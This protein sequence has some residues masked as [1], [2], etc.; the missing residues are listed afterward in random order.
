MFIESLGNLASPSNPDGKIPFCVAENKLT[1]DRLSPRFIKAASVAFSNHE[2]WEYNDMTGLSQMKGAV[3]RLWNRKV[4]GGAELVRKTDIVCG[5]GAAAVLNNTFACTCEVGEAVLIPAPYYAAFEN[6][7]EVLS[8][9]RPVKV[10]VGDVVRGPTTEEWEAAWAGAKALGLEVGA[11]L[12][13]NP[14]NPVGVCYRCTVVEEALKWARAKSLFIIVDEIYALSI[15][16]DEG[17]KFTSVVEIER[18]LVNDDLAVIWAMSKDFGGSGLRAGVLMT[19]NQKLKQSMSNI[20][21]FTGVSHPMQLMIADVLSDEKWVD[22]YLDYSNAQLR[23]CYEIVATTLDE[24][25][26]PYVKASA[27][28][29][30]WAD[31]SSLLPEESWEG[32]EGF[33]SVCYEEGGIV[34]TPGQAQRADRPGW[35]RICFGWNSVDVLEVGMERLVGVCMGIRGRGWV[36]LEVEEREDVTPSGVRRRGS[37]FFGD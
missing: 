23:K 2:S 8:G 7:M 35:F 18:G 34:M 27:G 10:V 30:V 17:E 37:S 19:G 33:T 14:N 6:D 11:I 3:A 26:V 21:V 4:C 25:D 32:E 16:G 22:K 5:A 29:F 12:V 24:I 1:Q 13:T 28:M 31:F 20:C 36:D 9:L 15:H